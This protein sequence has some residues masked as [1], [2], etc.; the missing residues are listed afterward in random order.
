MTFPRACLTA[1]LAIL[2]L[3]ATTG[4]VAAKDAPK[5][6]ELVA[7]VVAVD[8]E[9]KSIRIENGTGASQVLY[10]SGEAAERLDQISIGRMF[11]LTFQGSG[12]PERQVVIAIKRAKG[13][14]NT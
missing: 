5:T 10:V 4:P 7:K 13:V 14:P 2:A 6:H 3:V 9:A 12:D 1:G 8:L 11:R